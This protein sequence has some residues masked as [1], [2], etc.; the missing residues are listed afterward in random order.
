VYRR[1]HEHEMQCHSIELHAEHQ[2]VASL[3][4]REEMLS[5]SQRMATTSCTIY[6]Y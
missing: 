4:D 6:F 3:G 5:E 2:L 1:S